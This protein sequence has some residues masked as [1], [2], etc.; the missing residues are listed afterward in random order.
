MRQPPSGSRGA[1]QTSLPGDP[2]GS[3][4]RPYSQGTSV[5]ML[6]TPI[7]QT[8]KPRLRTAKAVAPRHTAQWGGARPPAPGACTPF[9][10]ATL[11]ASPMSPSTPAP[12]AWD[13]PHF[14]PCWSGREELQSRWGPAVGLCPEDLPPLALDLPGITSRGGLAL[15][16]PPG[17]GLRP[18]SLSSDSPPAHR[19]P[20]RPEVK[21][22][23]SPRGPE[24][25]CPAPEASL[26]LTIFS[27]AHWTEAAW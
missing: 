5:A 6:V 24:G 21:P 20:Y 12:E 26:P 14:T 18:P 19:S 23:S 2:C 11:E 9:A 3:H 27:L 10:P 25:G 17:A 4:P 8:Q 16:P 13:P 22:I 7:S 1:L 15:S